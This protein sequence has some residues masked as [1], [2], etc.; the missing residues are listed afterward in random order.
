MIN[1]IISILFYAV[2]ASTFVTKSYAQDSMTLKSGEVLLGSVSFQYSDTSDAV[3]L[4]KRK[5][6]ADEISMVTMASGEVYYTKSIIYYSKDRF[7]EIEK[8]AI[9]K[10]RLKGA[11]NL[12]VYEGKHFNFVI[13][14]NDRAKVIQELPKAVSTT[15]V[16]PYRVELINF[17]GKCIDR[18]QIFSSKLNVNN[19]TGLV[20]EYNSCVDEGYEPL[21]RVEKRTKILYAA[22]SIGRNTGRTSYESTVTA[23]RKS[24]RVV[25]DE[26]ELVEKKNYGGEIE[27]NLSGNIR[28]SKKLFWSTSLSVRVYSFNIDFNDTDLILTKKNYFELDGGLGLT[29]KKK[30]ANRF[31]GDGTFG[32]YAWIVP[33]ASASY[34]RGSVSDYKS[35]FRNEFGA[36]LFL[37]TK[38]SFLINENTAFFVGAKRTF[39]ERTSLEDERFQGRLVVAFGF[40]K[41]IVRT[42]Y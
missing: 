6:L 35:I 7:I 17:L 38:A 33:S 23:R 20:N 19:L 12:Y 24:R 8:A 14:N 16:Q 13:G 3:N 31:Y 11:V 36:G 28:E 41:K 27:V 5:Y 29:Y 10:E 18:Q 32:G 39:R 4:D 37:S 42:G 21:I 1:K 15:D 25:I 2:L 22:I 34:Q 9:L 30:I 26:V 40:T